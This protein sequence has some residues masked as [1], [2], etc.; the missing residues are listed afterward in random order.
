MTPRG[1]I[2]KSIRR[3]LCPIV[4]SC[5]PQSVWYHL[6]R[7]KSRIL[8]PAFHM[9]HKQPRTLKVVLNVNIRQKHSIGWSMLKLAMLFMMLGRL[10]RHFMLSTMCSQVPRYL[11]LLNTASADQHLPS[12]HSVV[13][14]W[15]GPQGHQYRQY[16]CCG[17][18]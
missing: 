12:P 9:V 3:R 18:Q 13:S 1:W 6:V 8:R 16:H 11:H 5:L 15:L 10:T 4:P 7:L 14:G 17:E 2:A